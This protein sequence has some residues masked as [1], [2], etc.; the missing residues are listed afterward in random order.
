ML[1]LI[2]KSGI[3]QDLSDVGSSVDQ[4]VDPVKECF[5]NVIGMV[6]QLSN[7]LSEESLGRIAQDRARLQQLMD[8]DEDLERQLL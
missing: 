2:S 7:F 4:A 8:A 1:E 5:I 3:E 6:N